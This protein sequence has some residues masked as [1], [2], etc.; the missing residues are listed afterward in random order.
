VPA[1]PK[2][3]ATPPPAQR[4]VS[5]PIAAPAPKTSAILPRQAGGTGRSMERVGATED[6]IDA[7]L[8]VIIAAHPEWFLPDG[9]DEQTQKRYIEEFDRI[10][11]AILERIRARIAYIAELQAA[12]KKVYAHFYLREVY[13]N[14]GERHSVYSVLGWLELEDV[15]VGTEPVPAE[16]EKT[17]LGALQDSVRSTLTG[18]V[19]HSTSTI[20]VPEGQEFREQLLVNACELLRGR[21][22]EDFKAIEASLNRSGPQITDYR[23]FVDIVSRLNRLNTDYEQWDLFVQQLE[24]I[25]QERGEDPEKGGR[26]SPDRSKWQSL[27]ARVTRIQTD[28]R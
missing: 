7:I 20:E 11:P 5:K 6:A 15:V 22:L 28:T 10:R 14:S 26:L 2:G 1:P 12:G 24:A 3:T 9:W 27:A 4:A 21:E 8:D 18:S 25:Y 17:I 23:V 16:R 19:R 13:V